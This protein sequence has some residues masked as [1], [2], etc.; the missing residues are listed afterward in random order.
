MVGS[1]SLIS[2]IIPV[3][4]RQE[5]ITDCFNS[6]IAQTYDNW[7]CIVVDDGSSDTTCDVVKSYA[8]KEQRIKVFKR[9]KKPKGAPSCR[10]SYRVYYCR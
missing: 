3:F 5:L 9:D 10:F 8:Q 7:E 2:I 1:S 6:I 4:N